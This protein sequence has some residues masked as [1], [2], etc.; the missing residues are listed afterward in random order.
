MTAIRTSRLCADDIR[1]VGPIR[2]GVLRLFTLIGRF[3][4]RE[5][6]GVVPN[7]HAPAEAPWVAEMFSAFGSSVFPFAD[8]TPTSIDHRR[9][10]TGRASATHRRNLHLT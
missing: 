3:R 1:T 10:R 2:R 5:D 4:R 7:S 9:E 6:L 8:P